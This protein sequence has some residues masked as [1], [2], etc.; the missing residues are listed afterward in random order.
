MVQLFNTVENE[1]LSALGIIGFP[2]AKCEEEVGAAALGTAEAIYALVVDTPTS[3]SG[4]LYSVGQLFWSWL[5]VAIDCGLDLVEAATGYKEIVSAVDLV[6][7]APGVFSA[8]SKVW[9]PTPPQSTPVQ[10][11]TSVDP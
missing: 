8:C 3:Q 11:V 10:I 2:D 1:I 6:I 9:T 7:N 4:Q 5:K